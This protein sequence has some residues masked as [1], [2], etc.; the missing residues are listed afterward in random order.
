M[1]GTNLSL[2][3]RYT[4]VSP[5]AAAA[6]T[7]ING[8]ILDMAGFD[9]VL[10]IALLGDVTDTSALAL[11]AQTNSVNSGTGMRTLAGSAAFTA[12]ATNADNNM[13]AL[14]VHKPRER[15]IRPVLARATAN[16]VVDGIIAV[17]FNAKDVP[18][19]QSAGVLALT[20]LNDASFV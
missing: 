3:A 19:G 13:L 18:P 11:T 12:G 2:Q 16:A 20:R 17:Q 8:S 5:S 14:E 1:N 4:R 7:A 9:S 6:T 15:F 10:F